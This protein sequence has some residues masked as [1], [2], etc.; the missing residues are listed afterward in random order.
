MQ[1]HMI[2]RKLKLRRKG[3]LSNISA[4]KFSLFLCDF[5]LGEDGPAA[6]SHFRFFA[7][8]VCC[9]RQ[10]VPLYLVKPFL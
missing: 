10:V 3:S 7:E 1:L 5:S 6:G 9:L 2:S 8:D 4:T